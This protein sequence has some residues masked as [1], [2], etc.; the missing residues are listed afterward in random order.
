MK[1][2]NGYIEEYRSSKKISLQIAFI[3]YIVLIDV[4]DPRLFP[5]PPPKLAPT[6]IL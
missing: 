5:N 2:K 3:T 4:N 6:R 1:N